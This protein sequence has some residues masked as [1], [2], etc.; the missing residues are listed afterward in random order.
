MCLKHDPSRGKGEVAFILFSKEDQ[1]RLHVALQALLYTR[2]Y[3]LDLHERGKFQISWGFGVFFRKGA[4]LSTT[5]IW[6]TGLEFF[7]R[8][9]IYCQDFKGKAEF[10]R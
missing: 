9:A 3:V 7:I 4:F 10:K 2:A 5:S 6:R 8:P 1:T